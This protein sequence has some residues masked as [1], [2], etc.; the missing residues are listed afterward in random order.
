MKNNNSGILA[1]LRKNTVRNVI[2]LVLSAAVLIATGCHFYWFRHYEE[3]IIPGAGVT[4]TFQLSEYFPELEGTY[5]D[6]TVYVLEGEEPGGS[7]LVLG[8]T[9]A[10]EIAGHMAAITLIES[11]TVTKGTLY[12]IPRTNNSA[13]TH[14]YPQEAS[15][16]I[17][18]IETN[19]GTREFVYGSR[20]TNPLDQWPD[21]D[22]YIHASSGQTLSG[23]ETRNL[24]RAYPGVA[25]GNLTEQIAYAVTNLITEKNITMTID[26][27]EASPEYPNINSTVS[28]QDALSVVA[29]GAID[30][31]L[32]GVSM[33]VEESPTTLH[34]LTHRELGDYTDTLALLM[35]TANPC[36]GRLRG[37]TNEALAITGIDPCY[38]KA[39]ELGYLYIDYD[40]T[41]VSLEERVARD[42]ASINVY[43]NACASLYGSEGMVTIEGMPSYD[44]LCN[45]NLG[46]WLN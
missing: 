21:P 42:L 17:V 18:H 46:D 40:E 11:A 5:G 34:G 1:L 43:A 3:V 26:L 31:D 2:C 30:L 19:S 41:G 28:H 27:H 22:I 45:G 37:A 9:H 33:R 15:P 35:E 16:E 24:N 12:V 10:D 7:M 32:D 25:T 36:Q 4:S 44:E 20:A 8:G 14:T 6:T 23:N 38:E 29:L 13:Y 39:A